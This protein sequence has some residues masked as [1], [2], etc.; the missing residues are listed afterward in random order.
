MRAAGTLWVGNIPLGSANKESLVR[1]FGKA[2]V[3]QVTVRV[4]Q[5]GQGGSGSA[6]RVHK[7]WAFVTFSD[8]ESMVRIPPARRACRRPRAPCSQHRPTYRCL[9][10]AQSARGVTCRATGAG[11][12]RVLETESFMPQEDGSAVRLAVTLPRQREIERSKGALGGT[13]QTHRAPAEMADQSPRTPWELHV[14]DRISIMLSLNINTNAEDGDEGEDT[15]GSGVVRDS[16]SGGRLSGWE[17]S[18]IGFT[19]PREVRV[20]LERQPC[21][22]KSALATN[23][24][25]APAHAGF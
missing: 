13:L 20:S 14:G 12:V 2:A 11:Q 9:P 21:R 1:V 23:E 7:S 17:A 16:G 6:E 19:C 10:T 25:L 24:M 18:C 15:D 5:R 4:K 8:A 3:Q 22:Q